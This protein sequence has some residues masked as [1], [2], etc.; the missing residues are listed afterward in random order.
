MVDTH[1]VRIQDCNLDLIEDLRLTHFRKN[2]YKQ[3]S[4]KPCDD[5]M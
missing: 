4:S 2:R 3:T 1:Q 5:Y